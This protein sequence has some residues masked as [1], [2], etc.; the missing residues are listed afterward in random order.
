[1]QD[2]I[3]LTHTVKKAGWSRWITAL[4]ITA[5]LLSFGRNERT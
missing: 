5:L 3:K 4:A 1:M 2:R